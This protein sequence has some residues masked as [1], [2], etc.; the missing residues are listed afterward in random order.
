MYNIGRRV[1][2]CHHNARLTDA[3]VDHLLTLHDSELPRK[4]CEI[5]RIVC[6]TSRT[7]SAECEDGPGWRI[8]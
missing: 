7:A 1:G 4:I 2:N 6:S 5:V 8:P 3:K